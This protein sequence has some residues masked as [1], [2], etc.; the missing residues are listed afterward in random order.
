MCIKAFASA[1]WNLICLRRKAAGVGQGGNLV[2][3]TLELLGG[4]TAVDQASL[5]AATREKL[6]LAFR[7]FREFTLKGFC[8]VG[9]KRASRLAQ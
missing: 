5:S 9:V 2:K 7:D 3:S 8:Y 1:T 6:R 4:F